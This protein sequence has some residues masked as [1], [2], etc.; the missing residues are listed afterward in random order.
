MAPDD[1][2]QRFSEVPLKKLTVML[3]VLPMLAAATSQSDKQDIW[4]P[5][6]FLEGVWEG[7]GEGP[8][9]V[10]AVVLEYRFILDGNF[11]QGATK[12]RFEPQ[13]ENAKGEIHEDIEL[14]S[15]DQGRKVFVLRGFYSEGFVNRYIGQI[16]ADGSTL[17]FETE[18]VENAPKGTRAKLVFLKKGPAELKQSFHVA[19]PGRDYAC[20]STN[21]LKKRETTPLP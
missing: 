5:L 16:S 20:M 19:W 11:L 18:A 13:A 6:R 14:L 8:G 15:Y 21:F 7:R 17:T 1:R 2:F 4:Q 3:L 12:A 9:G 10:S